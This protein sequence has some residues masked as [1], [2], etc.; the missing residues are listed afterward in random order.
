V[1]ETD[2]R[3]VASNI[4]NRALRVL[5][6][7]SKLPE[8]LQS[9][10]FRNPGDR[11]D[12]KTLFSYTNNTDLNF[13]QWLQQRPEQH[14]AFN[15]S[16]AASV[17]LE[18][19]HSP[20]G[21]ADLW[22]FEAE[23]GASITSP[24]DVAIVDIG[25]GYGHVLEDVKRHV[26]GLKGRMVLQDLPETIDKAKLSDGIEAMAYDFFADQQPVAGKSRCRDTSLLLQA[27]ARSMKVRIYICFAMCWMI[28]RM[29]WPR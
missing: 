14:T 4:V 5:P 8:Y 28:G 21:F 26:P 22:P 10:D 6:G 2:N 1:S 20:H 13:F 11:A 25:G 18:R 17:A 7:I 29:T 19:A 27:D 15:A 3:R 16:M 12:D 9:I 24:E 23:I